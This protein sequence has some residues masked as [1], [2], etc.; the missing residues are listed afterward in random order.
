MR[1]RILFVR[2][3]FT[4]VELLVVIGIIALLIAVLLPALNRAR[5][6]A[7][8][9][10]CLVNLRSM[11]QAAFAH[12]AEHQGYMPIAGAI[13]GPK[14][15]GIRATDVGLGDPLR[16][17]YLY[18]DDGDVGFRPL[19]LSLSLGKYMNVTMIDED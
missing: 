6:A 12:A 14:G 11:C 3:G 17:R 13:G 15:M 16:R 8:R 1:R 9:V 19:P 7:N 18:T 4:L 2:R 10:K 5:E